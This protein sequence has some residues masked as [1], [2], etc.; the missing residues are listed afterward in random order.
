MAPWV[1][2]SS[3]KDEPRRAKPGSAAIS[4]IQPGFGAVLCCRTPLPPRGVA[5]CPRAGRGHCDTLD[6]AGVSILGGAGSNLEGSAAGRA[7]AGGGGGGEG[8][9]GG[10]GGG[11]GQ[12]GVSEALATAAR[13]GERYPEAELFRL[14]GELLL[15]QTVPEEQLAEN[16][17]RQAID[18]AR[19]QRA[20]S[21][22]LRAVTSVS[23]LWQRQGKPDER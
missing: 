10:G 17:F 19:R 16:C 4:P 23:R 5:G 3:P 14:K 7:G 8:G 2:G 20:K 12:R 13:T 11:G 6:R 21:L 15:R 18:V 22:E 1:S 9:G